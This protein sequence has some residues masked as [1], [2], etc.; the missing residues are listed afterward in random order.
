MA[1]GTSLAT[2]IQA[3]YIPAV[4]EMTTRIVEKV[5]ANS[6]DFAAAVQEMQVEIGDTLF[7]IESLLSMIEAQARSYWEWSS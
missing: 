4:A 6:A 5:E 3:V 1:Q 7:N 2:N